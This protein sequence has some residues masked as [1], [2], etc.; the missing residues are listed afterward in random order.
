MNFRNFASAAALVTLAG[1]SAPSYAI[2]TL[3]VTS[4]PLGPG[5]TLVA[6]DQGG[7]DSSGTAGLVQGGT[8]YGTWTF[9]G[10][11]T[12]YPVLGSQ[13][14][15]HMDLFSFTLSSSA[16]GTLWVAFLD[17]DF[18][19][20]SGGTATLDIGGTTAGTVLYG[21]D[22]SNSN[23]S[24]ANAFVDYECFSGTAA[25]GPGAFSASNTCAI[26]GDSQ[27]ALGQFVKITHP[28]G[29]LLTTL[30]FELNVTPVPEPG[31]LA[32]LG[33]GLMGIAALRRRKA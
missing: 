32:L 16:G 33:M 17:T 4:D 27:F 22:V 24:D 21:L 25:A 9:S 18:S 8:T 20:P 28:Q 31:S 12:S 1:I 30:D 7:G 14:S 5:W 6:T 29:G 15:P 10:I 23:S 19:L 3:W 2:G 13:T 26:S 11:G